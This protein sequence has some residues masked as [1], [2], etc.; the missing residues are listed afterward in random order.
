MKTWIAC[1]ALSM[2]LVAC[3]KKDRPEEAAEGGAT[4]DTSKVAAPV[5]EPAA[6][7]LD[8]QAV[9]QAK[10]A[11]CHQMDV[12]G[13]GPSVKE[14]QGAYVGNADGIVAFAKAP[15]NPAKRAGGMAMPAVNAPDEE[16]KA[17]A[18]WILAQKF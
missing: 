7:G 1:I 2:A 8:G 4:V 11:A 14:M 5:A 6:G 15:A 16:L 18:D 3:S 10:C 12:A 9:F 17:A 13:V